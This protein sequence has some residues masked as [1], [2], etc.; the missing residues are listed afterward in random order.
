[1]SFS[2]TEARFSS[3]ETDQQIR[4]SSSR[5][6]PAKPLPKWLETAVVTEESCLG[7]TME[8]EVKDAESIMQGDVVIPAAH[9]A[10]EHGTVGAF[11]MSLGN[12]YPVTA[13]HVVNGN[14]T[15]EVIIQHRITGQ[16]TSGTHLECRYPD[17][18]D[19]WG[20]EAAGLINIRKEDMA[21]VTRT[22]PRMHVHSFTS[23]EARRIDMEEDTNRAIYFQSLMKNS[24]GVRV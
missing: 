15:N 1:V 5:T 18:R 16:E 10:E 23:G 22:I 20:L 8:L 21:L 19:E 6:E 4:I 14:S 24:G 13:G 11:M 17:P 3:A 12:L 9:R 7:F 2:Y